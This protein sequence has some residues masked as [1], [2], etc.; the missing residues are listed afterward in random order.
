VRQVH[1]RIDCLVE[2]SP[3]WSIR[4]DPS[5]LLSGF[6]QCQRQFE[7]ALVCFEFLLKCREASLVAS[8]VI[9][10]KSR[11]QFRRPNDIFRQSKS[12][13]VVRESPAASLGAVV[14]VAE[15][16]GPLGA[17][18]VAEQSQLQLRKRK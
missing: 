12:F 14:A 5:C 11:N 4:C 18:R 2:L 8:N 6:I 15:D 9:W 10:T 16:A 13:P 1:D 7:F 3:E 17:V